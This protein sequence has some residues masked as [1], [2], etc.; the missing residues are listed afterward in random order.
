M[1]ECAWK[2]RKH[3]YFFLQ[4][5]DQDATPIEINQIRSVK[6][7]RQGRSIPKAFEIFTSDKTYV[8][9]AKDG[10]NA[11]EWVQC[12][13]IAVASSHARDTPSRP[14]SQHFSLAQ[15]QFGLRTAV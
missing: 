5:L 8:L 1:L 9:K 15:S 2:L 6:V 7:G 14:P 13:S 11:E 3:C 12:L 4:K 10:K